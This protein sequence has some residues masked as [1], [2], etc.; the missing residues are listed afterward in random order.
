MTEHVLDPPVLAHRRET[1][2]SL[3]VAFAVT[4]ALLIVAPFVIYPIFLM[5]AL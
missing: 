3:G 5:K 4:V 1:A 2:W